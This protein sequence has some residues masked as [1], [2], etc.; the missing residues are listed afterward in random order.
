MLS[1][2]YQICIA[3]M[4]SQNTIISN[5]KNEKPQIQIP[6]AFYRTPILFLSHTASNISAAFECVCI[7]VR[8][9]QPELHSTQT[10]QLVR[11][12]QLN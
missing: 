6:I 8:R 9:G 5:R 2:Y 4:L 10:I 7:S 3:N 11:R 12:V 1:S